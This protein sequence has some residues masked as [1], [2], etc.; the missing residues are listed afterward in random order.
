MIYIRCISQHNV[1][2]CFRKAFKTKKSCKKASTVQSGQQ[3][4]RSLRPTKWQY[5]VH[6]P[7]SSLFRNRK[8][9][10]K[11]VPSFRWKETK[12][13]ILM[14]HIID[15]QL[16]IYIYIHIYTY[17]YIYVYIYIYISS[18][19]RTARTATTTN[20][21]NNDHC[22]NTVSNRPEVSSCWSI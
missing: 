17:I 16:N 6:N 4:C 22:N 1:I 13:G 3:S 10:G 7:G 2:T 8:Q 12:R 11:R 20:S 5:S 18:G 15:D 21:N 9:R 19:L 14:V